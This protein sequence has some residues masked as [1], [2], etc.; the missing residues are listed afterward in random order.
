[1]WVIWGLMGLLV[2]GCAG[3]QAQIDHVVAVNAALT[4]EREGLQQSVMALESAYSRIGRDTGAVRS[5]LAEMKEQMRKYD[6]QLAGFQAQGQRKS[7]RR[8]LSSD[9]GRDRMTA[10]EQQ[11]Q[12]FLVRQDRLDRALKGLTAKMKRKPHPKVSNVTPQAVK[13]L[14]KA[15]VGSA[16]VPTPGVNSADPSAAKAGVD[17]D[18][19]EF[20]FRASTI[21][22]PEL[23]TVHS[24]DEGESGEE[25]T[26]GVRPTGKGE[27]LKGV[28]NP[29]VSHEA[30][31]DETGPVS[32][33]VPEE[34]GDPLQGGAR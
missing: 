8:G 12:L 27:A 18:S 4:H 19:D 10:I 1:M 7:G 32:L 14:K 20:G 16:D 34:V 2:S 26:G 3:D 25:R 5:G 21:H 13:P 22:L 6:E 31:R 29:V 30:T 9:E 15:K 17:D 28:P 11:L 24:R 23:P 33:Q